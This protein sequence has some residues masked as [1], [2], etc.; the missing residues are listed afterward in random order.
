MARRFPPVVEAA[1]EAAARRQGVSPDSLRTFVWIESGGDPGATTGSYKGLLQLSSG[2][3]NKHGGGNIYDPND[4]LN[5]GALKLKAESEDFKRKYGRDPTDGDL[6]LIHQQGWGG[7]QAHWANP[8]QPA[9]QSM[10]STGEGQQK[11]PGWAKQAIWGN[12]PDAMKAKFGSVDNITSRDFVSLWNN[13]VAH[14]GGS[15]SPSP[16][17][18]SQTFDPATGQLGPKPLAMLSNAGREPSPTTVA[19]SS[20]ETDGLLSRL[21]S[22]PDEDSFKSLMAQA[23]PAPQIPHAPTPQAPYVHTRRVNPAEL[24]AIVK[25]R[26]QL[27]SA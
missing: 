24:L 26:S 20:G 18:T 9:W 17:T 11:G 13:K 5:A 14:F 6:Y 10:Y 21:F 3:F 12:V 4:N 1:I 15:S 25:R 27:G 16:Q 2:E 7:A 8:D 22:A 23:A 19:G